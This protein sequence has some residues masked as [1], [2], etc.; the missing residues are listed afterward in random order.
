MG[1]L[2]HQNWWAR[3]QRIRTLAELPFKVEI[4]DFEKH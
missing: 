1:I 4:V 2:K 3:S